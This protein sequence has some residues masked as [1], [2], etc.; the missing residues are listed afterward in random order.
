MIACNAS[1]CPELV[2]QSVCRHWTGET[3]LLYEERPLGLPG[4]L[5]E[6]RG[7]FKGHWIVSN[8]DIV[9][10][11]PVQEMVDFHLSSG[12]K[13]TV[14]T[15]DFPGYGSYGALF[16]NG[17]PRHYL[18]VSIISPEIASLAARGQMSTGFFTGLRK[19]AETAGISI[20]EYFTDTEW[21]DMG[22]ADLFRKHLLLQG[23]YIHPSARIHED[24]ELEGFCHVGSSC[25]ISRDA[26]LRRSVML[27]G[28]VLL[29]GASLVDAV[30]PWFAKR[31]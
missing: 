3:K 8:T 23:S 11:V 12:S 14:L 6:N 1:R 25:I 20:R 31:S 27:E 21:F 13:W 28:S 17:K 30:L 22:T 29:P 7:L 19:A 26:V 18:G 15:G 2:V 10:N 5:S 24:A 16:V 9:M 4:T